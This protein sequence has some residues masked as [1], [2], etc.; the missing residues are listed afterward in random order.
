MNSTHSANSHW[1]ALTN[2]SSI[3]HYSSLITNP[4]PH[5]HRLRLRVE[6][7]LAAH[8]EAVDGLQ[9]RLGTGF[10]DVG[11]DGLATLGS[12][13]VLDLD[14]HLALGVFAAG[15]VADLEVT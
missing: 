6:S 2:Q 9:E 7:R 13:F 1:R 11:A 3:T 8:G 12:A 14:A 10:D 15:D 4:L 5:R